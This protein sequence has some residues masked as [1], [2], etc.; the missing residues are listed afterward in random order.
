[1][2]SIRDEDALGQLVKSPVVM[3]RSHAFRKMTS[4]SRKSRLGRD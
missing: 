3:L 1:M 2:G 4:Y